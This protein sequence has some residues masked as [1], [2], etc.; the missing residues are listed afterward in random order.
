MMN[1]RFHVSSTVCGY[2]T[3]LES[4][5]LSRGTAEIS[6]ALIASELNRTYKAPPSPTT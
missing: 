2:Y 5:A 3:P 4:F 6:G 1:L